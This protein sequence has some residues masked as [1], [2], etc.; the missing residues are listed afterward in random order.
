MIFADDVALLT[1]D[2]N[3]LER[4]LIIF[5]ECLCEAGLKMNINKTEILTVSKNA[6]EQPQVEVNGTT[7]KNTD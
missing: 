2:K 6:N 4:A 5:N 7:I 1:Y 3:E